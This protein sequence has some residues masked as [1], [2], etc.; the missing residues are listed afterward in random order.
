[1]PTPANGRTEAHVRLPLKWTHSTAY[2]ALTHAAKALLTA[3]LDEKYRPPSRGYPRS[4]LPNG[5]IP[6]SSKEAGRMIDRGQ[7]AGARALNVLI[8][9]G[10]LAVTEGGIPRFNGTTKNQNRKIPNT[11][12]K[13]TTYRLT[14]FKD[15]F[16][17]EP[18]TNDWRLYEVEPNDHTVRRYV[19]AAG[20]T[21]LYHSTDVRPVI[22]SNRY[23]QPDETFV[24]TAQSLIA[25]TVRNASFSYRLSDTQSVDF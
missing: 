21:P 2:K 10:F 13:A 11:K 9:W 22:N 1:M 14:M 4:L 12:G 16:T 15:D 8:D 5:R 3:I 25:K 23:T 18:P 24:E 7:A 20:A 17:G 6:I 19:V